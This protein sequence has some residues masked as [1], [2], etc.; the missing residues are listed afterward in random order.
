[1]ERIPQE[2]KDLL[3]KIIIPSLVAISI[4]LALETRKGKLSVFN[5]ITSVVIGVGCAYLS[6]NW[7]MHTFSDG[8]IPIVIACI[9]VVGEKI[10]YWLIYKF[11]FDVV[12][13]S[14]INYMI[15]KYKSKK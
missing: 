3:I 12:G 15:E 14:L 7:V 5:A 8:K 4:K 2:L 9:T 13:D 10:A 11:D 1:M 6:S